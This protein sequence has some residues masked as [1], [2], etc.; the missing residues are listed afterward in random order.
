LQTGTKGPYGPGLEAL[1]PLVIV[2][3]LELSVAIRIIF[4]TVPAA[5]TLFSFAVFSLES[6][7]Y[8]VVRVVIVIIARSTPLTAILVGSIVFG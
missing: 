6:C 1:S 8:L 4:I 2:P 3:I 5:L 7:G